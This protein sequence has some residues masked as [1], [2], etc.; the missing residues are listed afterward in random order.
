MEQEPGGVGGRRQPI[1]KAHF[2][3]PDQ[4]GR[5]GNHRSYFSHHL[6]YLPDTQ[7]KMLTKYIADRQILTGVV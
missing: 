2:Q 1:A 7:L 4:K 3:F 5:H 6:F